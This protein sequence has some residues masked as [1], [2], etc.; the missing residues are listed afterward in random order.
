MNLKA[1]SVAPDDLDS[2]TAQFVVPSG[3]TAAPMLQRREPRLVYHR[4]AH[5]QP[6]TAR[7]W[8]PLATLGVVVGLAIG[9]MVAAV[10]ATLVAEGLNAQSPSVLDSDVFDPRSLA[11]VLTTFGMLALLLPVVLLGV[12]WGGGRKGTIHSV[13]G[14]VRWRLIAG[15]TAIVAPIYL[16]VMGTWALLDPP[17]AADAPQLSWE[18]LAV[19]AAILLV[20]PLQ[21]AAEEYAFRGLPMQIVGTWFRYAIWG[22]LIPVPLFMIGHGYDWVGQI[23]IAV[24]ALCM[25]FLVWK[26][27]G[28]ELAIVVHAVNNTVGV[29]LAW[30][31]DLGM[32][33]GAVEPLS[34]V[35][36]VSMTL[37]CTA[38]L[39]YWISRRYGLRALEPVRGR[40]RAP[41]R[42]AVATP[43]PA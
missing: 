7:W 31:F 9:V 17:P 8:R 39:T 25:G 24:F 4:L 42:P 29:L 27:G 3:R 34:M 32:E 21:S 37:V 26:S 11:A 40:G 20:V 14:R 18:S 16:V 38:A 35:I 5:L 33:Q 43:S 28:L 22:V 23:D 15:A 30:W 2:V 1:A 36:S 19:L 13:V 12:R 10:I 41:Q 6:R